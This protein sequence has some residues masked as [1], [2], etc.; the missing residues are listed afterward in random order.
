MVSNYI[1]DN[2]KYRLSKLVNVVYLINEDAVKDIRVDD[3]AAYI[4]SISQ[5]PMEL[6]CYGIKLSESESLDERYKFTHTLTFSVNGY[7]N[8][9]NFDGRY[10][11]IVKDEEG[12]Y[13]LINPLFPCKVT[14]TYNLGYQ[15]D[16][17]DFTL[18]T[19]SNHPVLE[20]KTF[21]AA[22]TSEC[23]RYTLGG[24]DK[25][26]L[27]ES[28][29][30]AH[31]ENHVKYTNDGGFKVVDFKKA[32]GLLS[33]TYNGTNISHSIKFTIE[34]NN[35]LSSWHYNLLEFIY[36]TYASVVKTKNGEYTLCGFN[37]GMQPTYNINADGTV[38]EINSI[39]VTL[40]D[41]HDNG[42]TL[43][44]FDNIDYEY[45]SARTW[46]YTSRYGGYECVEEG[47]ARYLLK[48]E[49]D[50]LGNETGRYM[51]Y[52]GHNADF[53][54]MNIVGTFDEDAR[55]KNPECVGM[56]CRLNASIPSEVVFNTIGCKTYY[57]NSDSPWSATSSSSNITISPTSGNSNVGYNFK[58][59][60][61]LEP[62]STPRTSTIT[63]EYCNTAATFNAKVVEGNSC[64][65]QGSTYNI[66]ANAQT[67][68][69][70]TKCCVESV[71]ET[72]GVGS[73]IN[74]YS[75]YI[76]VQVP[77]NNTGF[78]RTIT[79]LVIYCD[80]SSG[81]IIINQSDVFEAWLDEYS[82]CVGYDKYERQYKYT[83]HSSS[84]IT[85]RT[86]EYRDILVEVNSEDCGYV[87]PIYRWFDTED[88]ICSGVAKYHV[89]KQ[90]VSNDN[91]STWEDVIPI[92]TGTGSIW[93]AQSEDCGYI[94][95]QYRTSTGASY[96]IGF[97]RYADVTTE[98]S[99]DGGETWSEYDVESVLFD[100]D[101]TFCGVLYRW[102]P[103]GET[104]VGYDKYVLAVKQKSYN[105][106]LY[107][108]DVVPLTTSAT[109][110]IEHNSE[111][112]GF[113]PY[114]ER[115]VETDD[116]I[117]LDL[118][119]FASDFVTGTSYS[120]Q[121]NYNDELTSGD[122]HSTSQP[123]SAMTQVT[124]GN[125]VQKVGDNA[126][127]QCVDAGGYCQL[128]DT[129]NLSSVTLSNSVITLG[130]RS[131]GNCN[132]LTSFNFGESLQT[133][134]SQAF[135]QCRTLPSVTIPNSVTYIG[136]GAFIF[137]SGLTSVT[138][139]SSNV[140]IERE[141][142]RQC[143]NLK[144]INS[145]I[146]GVINI[147]NSVKRIA[148]SIFADTLDIVGWR[149]NLYIDTINISSGVRNIGLGGYY[150]NYYGNPF[151]FCPS[152]S[153]INVDGDNPYY[154]SNGN[155][156]AIIQTASNRLISG[157]K[158]TTIP[159]SVVTIGKYAFA[160]CIGL[161]HITIPNGV[162]TIDDFAFEY[163]SGLTSVEIPDSVTTIGWSAF[164]YCTNMTH[165]K[166]GSGVTTIDNSAFGY[167][168]GLTSVE[169]PD[170]VVSLGGQ[171][172]QF[173]RNLTTVTIGSG[174]RE[175]GWQADFLDCSSL[176]SVTLHAV[177][178]PIPVVNTYPFPDGCTLYVPAESVETYRNWV[179]YSGHADKIQPIP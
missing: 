115:W 25:L 79:L 82:S 78:Y 40:T 83:G 7:A 64:L 94:P 145:N 161:T 1:E 147:P 110:L 166:I 29:L 72:V 89:A 93:E 148:P 54:D 39:E 31:E 12:T 50:A 96:C 118:F 150:L 3:G 47:V 100:I 126:F 61:T 68:T 34:F 134:E 144:R 36:N 13:W 170:S 56:G 90:Q 123:L 178:P 149:L 99:Y 169:I 67:L 75:N 141:A 16:H 159:N 174:L 165:L 116:T 60:N 163:C 19:V 15:E 28:K 14:Y 32:S 172:F 73:I 92:T 84:S 49:Y 128:P 77:E 102:I 24:I 88:Y 103:S 97:N 6:G 59:C 176:Q 37:Y 179:V 17:T 101:S 38:Q 9:D 162:T 130:D 153:S 121:C 151:C 65:P 62:T 106:G 131:F 48:S 98:V 76:T 11:A 152:I 20:L 44:F 43:E 173:C 63:I 132:G 135:Y 139:N 109:T 53:A 168:S 70:P 136:D 85:S 142:F 86:D 164:Q 113:Q 5:A 51:A 138:I 87:E 8:K 133:I 18:S 177:I 158:N 107:W 80:G 45:L 129:Y 156:N 95:P 21:S 69:I 74:I 46:E 160:G 108:S 171:T 2:C 91:G 30:S 41:S 27:N 112:C 146:D 175:F 154:N 66:S 22:K 23:K 26:W 71:R 119:K 104:C 33:E 4:A 57:I 143:S 120:A 125:C 35:Y 124:I 55:F 117:C 114:Q 10:Y 81:N 122:T 140:E 137:C 157:C 58:I 105:N 42:G 167:C 155:C 52:S 127:N 111:D